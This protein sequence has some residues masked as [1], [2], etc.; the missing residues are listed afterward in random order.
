MKN[1]NKPSIMM[2]Y[3]LQSGGETIATKA[4]IHTLS[5][6]TIFKLHILTRNNFYTQK[7]KVFIPALVANIVRW[8]TLLLI[9]KRTTY[10]VTTHYYAGV[11]A[12][13][14]KPFYRNRVIFYYHGSRM[15][16]KPTS[17]QLFRFGIRHRINYYVVNL[18]HSF[19]LR[20][21][22]KIIVPSK[23]SI[24]ILNMIVGTEDLN[25]YVI[26][27]NGVDSKKFHRRNMQKNLY[28]KHNKGTNSF[29]W[30]CVSR[31]SPL[32]NIDKLIEAMSL[33]KTAPAI[34]WLVY[35]RPSSDEKSYLQL[36]EKKRKNL[37]VT[38]TVRMESSQ[39]NDIEDKYFESDAVILPSSLEISPLVMLEAFASGKI[40][41]GSGCDYV[42]DTLMKID[43]RLMLLSSNP[44]Y[45]AQ[46]MIETMKFSKKER[47]IITRKSEEFAKGHT[48]EKTAQKFSDTLITIP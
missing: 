46:K 25:K 12:V 34:L 45:L 9:N 33:M 6:K 38:K 31:L 15:L 18:L 48:L 14:L 41:L 37:N 44:Q 3:E 13:L 10:I 19:F 28:K 23:E 7:N 21:V 11:A 20:H 17:I 35:P 40:F 36:L 29:V 43:K 1:Q 39:Y 2:C 24:K 22:D 42:T 8:V 27:P 32:K 26:I 16:D 47:K 5:N 4:L 30:L